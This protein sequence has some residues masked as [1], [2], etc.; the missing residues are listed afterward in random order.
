MEEKLGR[1]EHFFI[2]MT[3]SVNPFLLKDK[4]S[5]ME[6]LKEKDLKEIRN[7]LQPFSKI[8]DQLEFKDTS[9]IQLVLPSYYFLCQGFDEQP[10]DSLIVSTFKQEFSK[11]LA[12]KF[13]K[14]C[15]SA[16][17]LDPTLREF[18]C[19]TKKRS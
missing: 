1:W 3:V 6:G 18:I 17:Y 12:D 11:S 5:L 9:T 7:F 10:N 2:C 4:T 19:I 8:F 16:T 13:Y 15:I 14:N